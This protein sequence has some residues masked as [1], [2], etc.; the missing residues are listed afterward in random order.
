MG[1]GWEA[2]GGQRE[3]SRKRGECVESVE[4]GRR[5]EKW[6]EMEEGAG[7]W[8]ESGSGSRKNMR[9]VLVPFS[10]RRGTEQGEM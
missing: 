6:E 4:G 8:M 7:R 1:G 10:R 5:R 3:E 2:R 9:N